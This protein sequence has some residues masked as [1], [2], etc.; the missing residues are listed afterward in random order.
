MVALFDKL[1]R[2]LCSERSKLPPDGE[3]AQELPADATDAYLLFQV[4]WGREGRGGRVRGEGRE[5]W[6][7]KRGGKG[8]VGG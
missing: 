2:Q 4:W 1:S 6:E 8:G 5:G 7:G 3:E